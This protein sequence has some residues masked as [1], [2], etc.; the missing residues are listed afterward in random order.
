MPPP[1]IAKALGEAIPAAFGP[2]PDDPARRQEREVAFARVKGLV[3]Q[4]AAASP[5]DPLASTGWWKAALRSV[6]PSGAGQPRG[7][8]ETT[9]RWLDREIPLV[10]S[11]P[12]GTG[13]FPVVLAVLDGPSP[14][15]AV[16]ALYGDLLRTHLVVGVPWDA[17]IGED[18]RM[19]LLGLAEAAGRYPVDPDRVVL[20]GTGRGAAAVAALAP[21]A[22]RQLAGV[23]LRGPPPPGEPTANLGLLSVLVLLGDGA[24]G[25]EQ[26]A[27]SVVRGACPGAEVVV[28]DPGARVAAWAAA[29]PPRRCAAVP[30]KPVAWATVTG[31]RYRTWGPGFVVR[32][33][34]GTGARRPVRVSLSFDRERN[35]AVV[36]TENVAEVLLLLTDDDLD[37]DRPVKVVAGGMVIEEKRVARDLDAVRAWASQGEPSL[38]VAAELHFRIPE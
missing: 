8:F 25:E 31:D 15:E 13:P 37:L 10:L 32:R 19:A 4:W 9:A 21:D 34:R 20:D 14:R 11:V 18:S 2:E 28:G 3:A 5:R 24:T 38:F 33:Y 22:A 23:V 17:A 35:A 36:E 26:A 16:P 6:L 27:A 1:E 30:R 7:L 12:R 29:V